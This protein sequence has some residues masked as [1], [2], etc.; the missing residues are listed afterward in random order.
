MSS[1]AK[2]YKK[3]S[4][5]AIGTFPPT[6]LYAGSDHLMQVTLNGFTESYQ[7]FF[8]QDIQAITLCH[9]IEAK[10]WS[11]V[12][13]LAAAFLALLASMMSNEPNLIPVMAS[14]F[15]AAGVLLVVMIINMA[16]GPTCRCYIKTAVQTQK[17]PGLKRV[18]RVR[19]VVRTRIQPLITQA[20][21]ELSLEELNGRLDPA[22]GHSRYQRAA[23]SNSG[24]LPAL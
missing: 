5:V 8:F 4:G 24:T 7:R 11:I 10:V 22:G 23:P 1:P 19:M 2:Q 20:Q 16:L 17:L 21:G 3:L 13:A 6:R 15:A 14:L 9:T 18:R 12:L